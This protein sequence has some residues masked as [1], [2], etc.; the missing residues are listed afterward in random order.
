MKRHRKREIANHFGKETTDHVLFSSK[1]NPYA[2]GAGN[3]LAALGGSPQRK[4]I[5]CGV[6]LCFSSVEVLLG[7]GGGIS[8]PGALSP[9]PEENVLPTLMVVGAERGEPVSDF[10]ESF[11]NRDSLAFSA[12]A[13][14][15]G[16]WR[17]L[18]D[19]GL[20]IDRGTGAIKNTGEEFTVA[21]GWMIVVTATDTG[22]AFS[23]S[24][25]FVINR[26]PTVTVYTAVGN[27]TLTVGEAGAPI[28]VSGG[29]TNPDGDAL[30]FEVTGLGNSCLRFNPSDNVIGGTLVGSDS[31]V[32]EITARY[33]DGS[34][35][36]VRQ[37]LTNTGN[38]WLAVSGAPLEDVL[39]TNDRGR[40]LL[41]DARRGCHPDDRHPERLRERGCL[42]RGSRR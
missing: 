3:R 14:R 27:R 42:L 4:V 29:F 7:C 23:A 8:P 22:R 32:V 18:A 13:I 19:F 25:T 37:E 20:E 31:V 21:D 33:P 24:H 11:A 17:E 36:A 6:G 30:I 34:D 12:L 41:I 38:H 1:R 15:D 35:R 28:D 10:F 40:E 9:P 26:T 39:L 2:F 16:E 5:L